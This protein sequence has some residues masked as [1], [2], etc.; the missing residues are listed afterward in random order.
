MITI[1]LYKE[2]EGPVK[3][4]HCKKSVADDDFKAKDFVPSNASSGLDYFNSPHEDQCENCEAPYV[5]QRKY[6]NGALVG[7]EYKLIGLPI[8]E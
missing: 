1:K 7:I 5:M 6:K 8:E 2:N 4:L 3:C